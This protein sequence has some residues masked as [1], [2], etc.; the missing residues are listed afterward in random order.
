MTLQYLL[1]YLLTYLYLN[2]GLYSGTSQ[3]AS[4]NV[5]RV[6]VPPLNHVHGLRGEG[7]AWLIGA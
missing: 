6:Q 5:Y 7:L 3:E 1:T 2:T 4:K